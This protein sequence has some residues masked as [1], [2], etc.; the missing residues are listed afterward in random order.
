[1]FRSLHHLYAQV[2]DDGAGRTVAA[3]STV[4]LKTGKNDLSAAQAVG[5]AIADKAKKAGVTAVVFDRGGFLYHGRI[6]AL[7]DA[8]REAG[9]EF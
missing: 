6:K 8:A 2:I 9:L 3:A 5:R 4:D 7:A 1:V